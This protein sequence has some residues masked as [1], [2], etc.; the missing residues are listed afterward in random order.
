MSTN[1]Q[2]DFFDSINLNNA[3]I[4]EI[5]KSHKLWKI[6]GVDSLY[7]QLTKICAHNT[8]STIEIPQLLR[9]YKYVYDCWYGYVQRNYQRRGLN[10]NQQKQIEAFLS[11][12]KFK[13]ENMSDM[14]CYDFVHYDFDKYLNDSGIVRPM[15]SQDGNRPVVTDDGEIREDFLHCYPFELDEDISCR[16][17]LNIKPENILE[18][19][20]KLVE[21]SYDKRCRVYFKFWTNDSR[22]DP[23][24]I[25]TNYKKISKFI[26][27][28]QEIKHENPKL[29]EGC[30]QINPFLTTI[31]GF[32]GFGEE[33]KYK[34]RSSFNLE[35]AQAISDFSWEVLD[36][37]IS[38][39][40]KKIG[41]YSG[42]NLNL[43]QYLIYRLESSF[44]ETLMMRQYDTKQGK[45]IKIEKQIYE[46]CKN[47]LPQH[48][49][50]QIQEMVKN[51]IKDLKD[52]R[53]RRLPKI[54]FPISDPE[55]YQNGYTD[56]AIAIDIN[57][58]EK[59]FDV[60]GSEARIESMITDEALAPY[61]KNQHISSK[62]PSLNIESED[63]L[64][65][66]PHPT[67]NQ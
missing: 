14:D 24:L 45:Y 43:E 12:E 22:N 64:S 49:K 4:A 28:I 54:R 8:N 50:L 15:N 63:A 41:N 60:F 1:P 56:Y 66:K 46:A 34:K 30:E 39:E 16:L 10:Q 48:V 17:Y 6:R 26:E 5:V 40:L 32:I 67:S 20:E 7:D 52:G 31:D 58:K 25:Y 21:K 62:C 2:A 13:K 23:F 33:P 44:K 36:K 19:V 59:L 65:E 3:S 53:S 55:L 42:V 61:L 37:V 18:L 51:Y 47:E 29:F 11:E 38:E 27:I 9:V 35:R 57:L